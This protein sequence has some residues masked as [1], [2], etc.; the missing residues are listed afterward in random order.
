MSLK[1]PVSA[2][3]LGRRLDALVF[4]PVVS[5]WLGLMVATAACRETLHDKNLA[6]LNFLPHW[7]QESLLG[8]V[9]EPLFIPSV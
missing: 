2:L 9:Q 4:V 7:Q 3:W 8:Q 5:I 1:L 6:G